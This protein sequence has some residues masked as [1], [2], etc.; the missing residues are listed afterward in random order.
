LVPF[1]HGFYR[2]IAGIRPNIDSPG[3]KEFTIAPSIPNDL[4]YVNCEYNSPYGKI[5]SNWKKETNGNLIFNIEI[6][7]G[8]IA[9]I[10]LPVKMTTEIKVQDQISNKTSKKSAN[11]FDLT[12]GKYKIYVN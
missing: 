1:L 7:K 6:P 9:T 4:S 10:I 11:I 8:S 5:I 2:Y 3:F 12:S